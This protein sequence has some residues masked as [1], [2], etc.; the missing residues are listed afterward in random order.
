MLTIVGHM[1]DVEVIFPPRK[2]L[3]DDFERWGKNGK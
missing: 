2:H 3:D 1:Q